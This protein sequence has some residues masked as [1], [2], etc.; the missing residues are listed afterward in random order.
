MENLLFSPFSF[1]LFFSCYECSVTVD[2][3]DCSTCVSAFVITD[4]GLCILLFSNLDNLIRF[5]R[6][7]NLTNA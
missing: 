4:R 7:N 2:A 6:L 3:V 1:L 5:H